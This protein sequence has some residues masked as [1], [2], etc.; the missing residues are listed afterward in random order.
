MFGNLV[1]I[2]F[3]RLF[4]S[5][6]LKI[7]AAIAVF[8]LF[9]VMTLIDYV[10]YF[11]GF[12][13]VIQDSTMTAPM[14]EIS[15]F[16][17]IYSMLSSVVAP[18]TVIYTTCGYQ[19]ARLSVNIEGAVRN[20]LKLCLS[21]LTGIALMVVIL[22]LLVLPGIGFLCLSYHSEINPLD[23]IK[24]LDLVYIFVSMVLSNLYGCL[25]AY[26]ISKF[27]SN[28]MLA[29]AVSILYSV[30]S[31]VGIVYLAG[32]ISGNKESGPFI[33]NDLREIFFCVVMSIPV[34]ALSTALAVRYKKAD[35]I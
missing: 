34:I 13:F 24:E 26:L 11:G 21:E 9:F 14:F 35:R 4:K 31:Y 19:K 2:E 29:A 30:V 12:E 20:R 17:M 6:A 33:P 10:Q 7:S 22:S 28:P 5:K 1:Q 23:L 16:V 25:I 32:F 3:I 27:T 15:V 18:V 8:L